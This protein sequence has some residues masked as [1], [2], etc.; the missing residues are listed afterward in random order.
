[1]RKCVPRFFMNEREASINGTA[2]ISM[3]KG[4][5]MM[6]LNLKR[7]YLLYWGCIIFT[8]SFYQ[9]DLRKVLKNYLYINNQYIYYKVLNLIQ[10]EIS[11]K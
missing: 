10:M 7:M 2:S 11:K 9:L 5:K 6:H 4:N 3:R 8:G 1:M